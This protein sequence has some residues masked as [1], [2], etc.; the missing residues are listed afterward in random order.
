MPRG[1][2][3]FGPNGSGKSTVGREL[4][5]LL[6]YK[7]MDIEDYHFI[8]SEIPYTKERSRDECLNLMLNDIKKHEY[9][10]ISAVTGD[11]GDE[12]VSMYDF[13]VFITAPLETRIERVKKRA[14]KK[15]GNRVSEGGDMY[16]ANI[17]FVNF[18]KSRSL[19]KLGQWSETLICPIIHVDGTKA[20]SENVNW[21]KQQ[22]LQVLRD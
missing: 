3:V 11:F 8:K 18:V 13:G 2:I 17:E 5:R 6:N 15:Y 10:V 14:I 1:I 19:T 21:I 9:F 16:K 7:Y 22:Y 20:I 12:I 4:A